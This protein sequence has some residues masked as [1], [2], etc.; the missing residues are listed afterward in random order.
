MP[1]DKEKTTKKDM[2]DTFTGNSRVGE[3]ETG[4]EDFPSKKMTL[5]ARSDSGKKPKSDD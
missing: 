3:T 5:E 4:H 2:E 1:S